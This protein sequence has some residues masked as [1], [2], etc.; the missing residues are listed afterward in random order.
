MSESNEDKNNNSKKQND[1]AFNLIQ[2]IM[3]EKN[4]LNMD[5]QQ[6]FIN[7]QQNQQNSNINKKKSNSNNTNGSSERIQ[8]MNDMKKLIDNNDYESIK[9]ILKESTMIILQSKKGYLIA[10]FK[11]FFN[12]S[13]ILSSKSKL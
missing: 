3:G 6:N 9:K 1:E 2:T 13:N 12:G 10:S 11:S 7:P 5:Q 4:L 8:I